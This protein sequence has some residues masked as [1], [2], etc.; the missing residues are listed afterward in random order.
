MTIM[1]VPKQTIKRSKRGDKKEVKKKI[2]NAG[3]ENVLP[4]RPE[5]HTRPFKGSTTRNLNSL[6]QRE[7]LKILIGE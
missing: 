5:M 4:C 2:C 6:E 7:S 1:P 3:P